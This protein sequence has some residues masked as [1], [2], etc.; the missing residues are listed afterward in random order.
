MQSRTV[1]RRRPELPDVW[2]DMSVVRMTWS[3]VSVEMR[4]HHVRRMADRLALTANVSGTIAGGH[5]RAGHWQL[6][7]VMFD[8]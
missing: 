7:E 4:T 1:A 8:N 5:E 6:R 3:G 2:A